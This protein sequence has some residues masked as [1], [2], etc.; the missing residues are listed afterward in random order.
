MKIKALITKSNIPKKSELTEGT[1]FYYNENG[2][3]VFT[4]LYHTLRGYCCSNGCKCC[5]Y[6]FK[7]T[8]K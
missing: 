7:K 4:E 6:G 1:H 8:M 5:P 2:Y 3:M